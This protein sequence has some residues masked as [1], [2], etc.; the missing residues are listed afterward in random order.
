MVYHFN[1]LTDSTKNQNNPIYTD[2]EIDETKG[3]IGTAHDFKG[4]SR[5]EIGKDSSLESSEMTFMTWVKLNTTLPNQPNDY[6][7]II[8]KRGDNSGYA[9]Y[10]FTGSTVPEN[11][12]VSLRGSSDGDN[13]TTDVDTYDWTTWQRIGFTYDG[14]LLKVYINGEVVNSYTID[15]DIAFNENNDFWFSDITDYSGSYL[16]GALDNAYLAK[17]AFNQARIKAEYQNHSNIENFL[18]VG[19]EQNNN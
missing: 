12:Q 10:L 19:V 9:M 15:H 7:G 5:I 8:S 3:I 1:N 18:Q 17:E 16:D 6:P 14:N 2:T 11:M 13:Y 4:E